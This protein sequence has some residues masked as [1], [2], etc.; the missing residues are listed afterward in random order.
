MYQVSA[1]IEYLDGTLA[2]VQIPS[3]YSVSVPTSKRAAQVAS[4]LRA[5]RLNNDFIRA[6][7][8]GNRYRVA[9]RIAVDR[10]QS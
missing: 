9:G 3:G 2:G 5:V 10:V 8:T 4:W 1:D 7:V 6:A